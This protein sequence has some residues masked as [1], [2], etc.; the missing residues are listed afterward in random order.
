MVD[1][2]GGGGELSEEDICCDSSW[3]NWT[4]HP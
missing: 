2:Q 3:N 4:P 1:F